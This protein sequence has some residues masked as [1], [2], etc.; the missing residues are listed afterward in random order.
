MSALSA[1]V[2]MACVLASLR[3]LA[4]AVA[5]TSFDSEELRRA[6]TGPRALASLQEAL[7]S[8]AETT[9][10][11]RLFSA[12]AEH[13]ALLREALVNEL[14]T[15]VGGLTSAWSRVPRICAS[16]ATS[17]GFLFAS[18]SLLRSWGG[19]QTPPSVGLALVS[20]VDAFSLGFMATAFCI[21]IHVR[22]GRAARHSLAAIDRLVERMQ[23]V[24][25]LSEA[26]PP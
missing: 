6:M 19:A 18:M 20:A 25:A 26:A 15:E 2:A 5:P 3:R 4:V 9:W 21:V 7:G 16:L 22:A 12:F 1:L 10:E 17:F 13:D 8:A 11:G 14:L 23:A 24:S